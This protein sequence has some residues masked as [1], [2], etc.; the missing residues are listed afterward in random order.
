MEREDLRPRKRAKIRNDSWLDSLPTTIVL[1][2]PYLQSGSSA[3]KIKISKFPQEL[4]ILLNGVDIRVKLPGN[5]QSTNPERIV[6]IRFHNPLLSSNYYGCYN[7]SKSF[8]EETS[9]H[10]KPVSSKQNASSSSS[11][12]KE[13]IDSDCMGLLN[14]VRTTSDEDDFLRCM[15]DSPPVSEERMT[16]SSQDSHFPETGFNE[17][18]SS[19]YDQFI[20]GGKMPT[21]DNFV[22][23]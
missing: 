8:M 6:R 11:D 14:G 21:E 15:L 12:I 3:D 9:E 23:F 18:L 13:T 10:E 2:N 22:A 7:H 4:S 16:I 20:F 19:E 1:T 17:S 5:S